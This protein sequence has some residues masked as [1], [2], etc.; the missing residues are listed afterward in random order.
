MTIS[1]V[2]D[3][4]RVIEMEKHAHKQLDAKPIK[5]HKQLHLQKIYGN[6]VNKN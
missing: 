6:P 2:L 5:Q 4:R 1:K 3:V